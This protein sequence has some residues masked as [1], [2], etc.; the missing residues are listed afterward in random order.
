MPGAS[1]IIVL[2]A[3]RFD[4]TILPGEREPTLPFLFSYQCDTLPNFS[5]RSVEY[6]PALHVAIASMPINACCTTMISMA[7]VC[8]VRDAARA[9]WAAKE[10]DD[11][12][13]DDA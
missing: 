11:V 8:D 4:R 2:N 6:G 7:T 1:I 10:N 13:A 12:S 3:Y 5:P 9:Y